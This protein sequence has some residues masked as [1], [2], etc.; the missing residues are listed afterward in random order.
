MIYL[1]K[2]QTRILTSVF[3]ISKEYRDKSSPKEIATACLAV[4]EEL[5]SL[6]IGKSEVEQFQLNDKYVSIPFRLDTIDTRFESAEQKVVTRS[7]AIAKM[8]SNELC[9]NVYS[10]LQVSEII[11]RNSVSKNSFES[12]F[13]SEV[14]QMLQQETYRT[15]QPFFSE[16]KQ[17][18]G[19][20][21]IDKAKT[22]GLINLVVPHYRNPS[23]LT[24]MFNVLWIRAYEISIPLTSVEAFR[25]YI[26]RKA[27]K[28]LPQSLVHGS[29]GKPSHNPSVSDFMRDLVIYFATM[30]PRHRSA[31]AIHEDLDF[32]MKNM[33]DPAAYGVYAVSINWISKFIATPEAIARIAYAKENP[34]EFKQRFIGVLRFARASAPL[35]RIYIDGYS[36]QLKTLND[37]TGKED[38]LVGIFVT[39]DHSS[40]C[41]ACEIGD[42]EDKD[43]LLRALEAYFKKVAN[44]LPHEIVMD[45][46]T[47]RILKKSFKHIHD[48]LIRKGVII[49]PTSHPNAKRIERFFRTFQEKIL[50]H[51]L[52]YIGSGLKSK[53]K[54]SHP[55]KAFLLALKKVLA[56]K[57]DMIPVLRRLV[58]HEFNHHYQIHQ[59]EIYLTPEQLFQNLRAL[60][61]ASENEARTL[62]YDLHQVT[63]RGA[64]ITIQRDGNLHIYLNR[65]FKVITTYH[66]SLVDAY[67]HRNDTSK[68][69]LHRQDSSE[70]LISLD[71]LAIIPVSQID[72]TEHDKFRFKELAKQAREVLEQFKEDSANRT[73]RIIRTLKFDPKDRSKI[74]ELK[75]QQ[76]TEEELRQQMNFAE[77]ITDPPKYDLYQETKRGRKGKT[78]SALENMGVH[79]VS[80]I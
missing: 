60:A 25:K 63:F 64:G 21:V 32:L 16:Y 31:L 8:L 9:N 68:I 15:Y 13:I 49:T 28:G 51:L 53:A 39:D 75:K 61:I 38:N 59:D 56:S 65:D 42:A 76:S 4:K 80:T 27:T 47:Y 72:R 36:F 41:I 10:L 5:P 22:H 78:K 70:L 66:G 69:F 11:L 74:E 18:S 19:D 29:I 24:S 79:M 50:H 30:V 6:L 67:V 20:V 35:I 40:Y 33:V 48:Y 46:Y 55:P 3:K 17:F 14:E 52:H 34:L 43:L 73:N 7:G 62:F 45:R 77:D 44:A 12:V 37:D 23:L 1:T 26:S 54:Y 58:K 57:Y 2:F 71:E